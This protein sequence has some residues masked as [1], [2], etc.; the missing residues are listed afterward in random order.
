MTL[1]GG[2]E[3]AIHGTN[4]PRWTGGFATVLDLSPEDVTCS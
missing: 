2:G 3:Y 4:D 1:S